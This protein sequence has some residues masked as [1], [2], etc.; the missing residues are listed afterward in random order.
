MRKTVSLGLLVLANMLA[1][2]AILVA[3][4]IEEGFRPLSFFHP[5]PFVLA[6]V[7]SAQLLI[8]AMVTAFHDPRIPPSRWLSIAAIL[9]GAFTVF[10]LEAA[11]VWSLIGQRYG[12]T[13]F[14]RWLW[15]VRELLYSTALFATI[16]LAASVSLILALHILAWPIRATF[17]WRLVRKG[18]P[19]SAGNAR[20]FGMTHLLAWVGFSAALMWLVTTATGIGELAVA[21][22]VTLLLAA[23]SILFVAPWS[24]LVI[25]EKFK[26]W[27]IVVTLAALAGLSYA[28]QE[29]IAQFNFYQVTNSRSVASALL[30]PSLQF[31]EFFGY[32]GAITLASILNLLALRKMGFR[33]QAAASHAATGMARDSARHHST[34]IAPPS[35]N[36]MP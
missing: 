28:A 36:V 16:G 9:F 6:G 4:A 26:Y 13:G 29:G 18:D 33:F 10:A 25:K 23:A 22:V 3:V 11:I 21:F 24:Y 27:P 31:P 30:L 12:W 17:G 20:Q 1:T 14:Q 19:D 8:L 15:N 2:M 7:L 35:L 5:T 34:T 32:S